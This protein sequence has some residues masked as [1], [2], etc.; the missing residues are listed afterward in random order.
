MIQELAEKRIFNAAH[1][2]AMNYIDGIEEQDVYPSAESRRL[3]ENF[4][5][6]LQT[7]TLDAE[8]VLALLNENGGP[9]TCAQ[10][11]GRYFGFVNGGAVPAAL[12]VKWLSDVWDQNG[13]LYVASPI[14]GKLESVCEKWLKEIFALPEQTIVSF[15]SGTTLANLTALTAARYHLLKNQGWDVNEQGLYGAPKIKIVAH[16]QV[17][18]SVKKT[19][20]LLGFGLDSVQWLPSDDQGR[21]IP[22]TLP[23]L[24]DSTLVLMQAGN[25]NTGSY[26]SFT[27]VCQAAEQAGA[28]VH[29]DGAFGLWA[30]ACEKL[31][32][33]TAGM[34]LASSWS[35]D[36]H[37]TLNAPYDS[38]IVMCKHPESLYKAMYSKGEYFVLSERDSLSYSPEMSKRSRAI[39]LWATMKYLGKQGIDELVLG[40]HQR[41][42]QLADGLQQL[43]ITVLNEVVFNQVL[44]R[45]DTEAKTDALVEKLQNSGETWLGGTTWLGQ[46]A[47]RVSVCSWRTSEADIERIVRLFERMIGEV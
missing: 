37:K 7:E 12:A 14:N 36:A 30:A 8:K 44:L 23:P 41:A 33:L 47:M 10:I 15:V 20:S 38:G 32:H 18:S 45:M 42:L 11:G 26:D 13:G 21:Y 40:L 39:E 9:N 25:A 28:W 16:E 4:D 1:E 3:L 27:E 22:G 19:I 2:A 24:D 34:H 17:H 5:E 43:D 46:R 35:V 31:K 29:I 6:P